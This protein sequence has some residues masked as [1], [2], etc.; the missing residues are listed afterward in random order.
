MTHIASPALPTDCEITAM[1]CVLARRYGERAG[2]VA[3]H[4]EQEHEVV[5]DRTRAALWSRVCSR[6]EC[7]AVPP[8]LS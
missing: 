6:L 5:G 4:F 7:L 8:T 2:E 1:A 3:R